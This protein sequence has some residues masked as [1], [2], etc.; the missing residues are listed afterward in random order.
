MSYTFW[1]KDHLSEQDLL[2]AYAE[3]TSNAGLERMLWY[4]GVPAGPQSWVNRIKDQW[5][6][7]VR[8]ASLPVAFFWLNGYQG[9]SAQIH[10]CVYPEYHTS[11]TDIGRAAIDWI[12][13]QGWLHSLYGVTP[14]THRHVIPFIESIGFKVLGKLPGACFIERLNKHVAAYV[15]CYDFGR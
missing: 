12:G 10:F 3:V 4:D 13:G 9:R 7:L 1:H 14:V 8:K 5:F 6:V 2:D 15:S 11:A